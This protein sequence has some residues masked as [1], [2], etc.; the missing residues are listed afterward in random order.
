MGLSV[1][2]HVFHSSCFFGLRF[3]NRTFRRQAAADIVCAQLGFDFG[4][5]STSSCESYGGSNVCGAANSPVAMASLSCSGGELDI[6]DCAYSTPDASC[7]GHSGDSVVFCGNDEGVGFVNSGTLRLLDGDGAPSFDGVGRLEIFR[8][9]TWGPICFDGFNAGAANVACK[10]MG[11]AG[12]SSDGVAGCG[13]ADRSRLCGSIAPQISE[14]A[15]VGQELDLLSCPHVGK[16]DVFCSPEESVVLHCVGAGDTQ[17][18]LVKA[19]AP[20]PQMSLL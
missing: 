9:N 3:G 15:C 17:G 12:A 7:S 14:V 20:A 13:R 4:I 19:R 16:D 5:V 8:D 1:C 2:E 10:A 11:F 18:R 6:R